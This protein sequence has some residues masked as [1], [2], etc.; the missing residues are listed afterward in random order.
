MVFLE[1]CRN[2]ELDGLSRVFSDDDGG[3]LTSKDR[4][5][6]MIAPTY[7]KVI[8]PHMETMEGLI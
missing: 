4:P 8:G 7:K 2:A 3:V 6:S 5:E 1:R